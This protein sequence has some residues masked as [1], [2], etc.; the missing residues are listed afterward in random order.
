[1]RRGGR[2]TPHLGGRPIPRSI[3][4]GFLGRTNETRLI[5]FWKADR[6]FR[7]KSAESRET[8]IR[9]AIRRLQANSKNCHLA[10]I[11]TAVCGVH[12]RRAPAAR[13]RALKTR[14]SPEFRPR[15]Q[16]SRNAGAANLGNLGIGKSPVMRL[17]PQPP[18]Q[19]A[20]TLPQPF[21]AENV[22]ELHLS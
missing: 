19:A 21:A 1:M 15:T 3:L 12:P 5:G 4:I 14:S 9:T 8:A 18:S 6:Q 2:P 20:K 22:E 13:I 7:R 17:K 11:S 16:R 10:K